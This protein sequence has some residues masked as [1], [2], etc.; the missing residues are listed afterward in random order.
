MKNYL[1]DLKTLISNPDM[2]SLK[3]S[4]NNC[5]FEDMFSLVFAGNEAGRLTRAFIAGKELNPYE[6]QI[7]THRYDLRITAIK[8]NIVHHVAW[9]DTGLFSV[10]IDQFEY[11][12]FLNGGN[13]LTYMGETDYQCNDY[14]IPIGSSVYLSY[15]D[16]HTMSCSKGA[17]W[18]V[19]EL[20]FKTDVSYVLGVP[21]VA[22][23]LYTEPAMF[24]IN[25]KCQL[26]QKEINK[27]LAEYSAV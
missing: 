13:G 4:I 24:Q 17:I 18:V 27:L 1:Q 14:T 5:H 11:R 9:P 22:D 19:E 21:F 8:G 7:H 12:S 10:K 25:D 6:V 16:Y 2:D 20:G 23:D 15:K 3:M 26:V